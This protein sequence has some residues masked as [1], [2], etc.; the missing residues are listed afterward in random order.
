MRHRES[1]VEA[2]V[3]RAGGVLQA[4]PEYSYGVRPDW[5]LS[6]QLPSAE[7]DGR[8]RSI[9]YR[10]ELQYVAPHEA[11]GFYWG[12]NAEVGHSRRTDE[13]EAWGAE[14]V[15]ILGYRVS[16][17][18]LIANPGF[19]APLSGAGRTLHFDPAAKAAYRE[20]GVE[21]YESTRLAFLVWDGK[22]GRS[23]INFGLGR[24]RSGAADRWVAKMIVEIYFP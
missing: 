17:W 6:F 9:G 11:A 23:D 8:W 4:M 22:L 10:V 16:R 18:Q 15:P 24:G 3:N 5:E 13:P 7:Q 12:W 14:L 19:S 20:F 1:S 21:Y 2:H